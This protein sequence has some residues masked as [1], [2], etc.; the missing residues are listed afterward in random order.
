MQKL[1]CNDVRQFMDAFHDNEVDSVTSLQIQDHLDSCSGCRSRQWWSERGRAALARIKEKTP[2]SAAALHQRILAIPARESRERR[3]K[4]PPFVLR[5]AAMLIAAFVL[6]FFMLPQTVH[7]GMDARLFVQNHQTVAVEAGDSL[8]LATEDPEEAAAWLT[9]HLPASDPPRETPTGFRLAGARITEVD[10][11]RTGLLLYEGNGR[12]I[13]CFVQPDGKE[14]DRGFDEVVLREDGI[15]AGRC[16]GHQI[17]TWAGKSGSSLVL[18]GDLTEESL[19]A[20]AEQ[21]PRFGSF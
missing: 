5:V 6:T 7:S 1:N 20:F 12:R 2:E 11:R 18:V 14:V 17:V 19:L 13:S 3:W 10:G 15:R 4:T 21:S 9:S 8:A 16:K